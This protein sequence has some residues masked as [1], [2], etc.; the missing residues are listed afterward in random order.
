MTGLRQ[1]PRV[2]EP[3]SIPALFTRAVEDGKSFARAEVDY[4]KKMALS[5]VSGLTT[6]AVLAI[7][8]L[9]LLQA[10]LTTLVVG[11]GLALATW[12]PRLGIAGGV[13]IAAVLGLLVAGLLAWLAV[14]RIKATGKET[15]K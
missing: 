11:F 6:A 1:P 2:S 3:E 7:A 10:S 14:G 4:Y 13:V 15:S 9:F 5:R 8:A 12:L